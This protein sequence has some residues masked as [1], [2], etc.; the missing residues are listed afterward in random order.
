MG[1]KHNYPQEQVASQLRKCG[2]AILE[3]GSF[4]PKCDEPYVSPNV[5]VMLNL[6]GWVSGGYDSYPFE[7]V[8]H[9][10]AVLEPNHVIVVRG[11][12]DNYLAN[13]MVISGE[14]D[15]LLT[16]RFTEK[17]RSDFLRSP[18]FHLDDDQY[19]IVSRFFALVKS[20]TQSEEISQRFLLPLMESFF[21]LVNGFHRA[22]GYE[23]SK[24]RPVFDL[25]YKELVAHWR[26]SREVAFYAEKLHYSP[27]YFGTLVKNETGESVGHWI[28]DYVIVQAKSLLEFQ[29]N[30]TV[31]EISYKLGF[32]DQTVF[33]RWF[34]FHAGL[35][36][37]AFRAQLES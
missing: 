8:S 11:S 7:F 19:A 6:R 18:L 37:K 26:E 22:A 16:Q 24:P 25:F 30:M 20:V 33:S 29:R 14:L 12:S 9:D 31:Q 10:I 23:M 27:K 3:K 17:N 2:L 34:K 15:G 1:E 21:V 35:S 4:L 36:P 32:S 28:A 5:V 13:V